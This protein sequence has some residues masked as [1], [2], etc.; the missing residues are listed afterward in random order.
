MQ[1]PCRTTRSRAQL[2]DDRRLGHLDVNGARLSAGRRGVLPCSRTS[3]HSAITCGARRA[4]APTEETTSIGRLRR[5]L[6]RLLLLFALLPLLVK[7]IKHDTGLGDLPSFPGGKCVYKSRWCNHVCN[8]TRV[9]TSTSRCSTPACRGV[10][11]EFCEHFV[12][13]S[14]EGLLTL[15]TRLP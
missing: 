8:T 5:T 1:L 9:N 15:D 14:N 2:D 3:R 10:P 7:L 4:Q 6:L 13:Q 12:R 11:T